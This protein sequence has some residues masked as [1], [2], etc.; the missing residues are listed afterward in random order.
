MKFMVDKVTWAVFLRAPRLFPAD[1]H[2]TSTPRLFSLIY[3]RCCV[4][5]LVTERV[6]K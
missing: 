3:H 1:Y 6:G 5:S 4:A 2:S